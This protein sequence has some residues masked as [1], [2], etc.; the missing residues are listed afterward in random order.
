MKGELGLERKNIGEIDQNLRV[1]RV[2][3]PED[4]VFYDVRK[5]PFDLYG[6]YNPRQEPAFRRMP[7][8]TAKKVS[9]QV[10]QLAC[11]T[12]GG[13]VRFA[14]DSPYLAIRAVMPPVCQMP[15]MA[16][17]ASAGFDLYIDS[18][19]ASNYYKTFIP[20]IDIENGYEF[21]V[22]LPQGLKQY[23][24][25]F[26][27]YSDV[28][29]LYIG[30][31][32]G[33]LLQKGARYRYDNPVVYYGSSITQG[34][35]ASRPGNSYQAIISRN[36][37]CD[38]INLGFSGSAKAEE[39]IARYLSQLPA[40]VFV[41][42]YDHNAETVEDLQNTHE[43]LFLIYRER[44]PQTPVVFISRPDFDED[45]D[46][47]AVRRDVIYQTYAKARKAGD[48]NIY[49]IDGRWLF[50][51]QGRDSCTVDGCHPSD[52]GFMRMAE[53]IGNMISFILKR[54]R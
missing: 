4:V 36:L 32:Q 27:L 47:S 37:D 33:S 40:S 16:L 20:P 25:N 41:C 9:P 50:G 3:L 30:I 45:P 31:K 19:G 8:V 6:L 21:L 42:D 26:P 38:Y 51:T 10:R 54:E 18:A 34:A 43:R 48:Q 11:N 28:D 7:D 12:A 22:Q 24:I 29:A 44:H 2:K 49:F 23:T 1:A 13:R 52:L 5:P 53:T 39:E 15:H 17:C 46:E 14:T 35:C